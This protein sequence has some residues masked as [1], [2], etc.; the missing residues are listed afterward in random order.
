MKISAVDLFCGAGGLTHGFLLEK[1]PV[2]AGVDIDPTCQFPYE[3]NNH[4]KFINADIANISSSEIDAFYPPDTDIK[5]L[6]GCAPCQPFSAHRYKEQNKQDDPRW[7]LL[8]SFARIAKDIRPNLITMENVPNLEHHEIYNYFVE[9]LQES[10]YHVTC[11]KV[12]CPQYG[13]PQTRRRLVMFGSLYGEVKL[14]NPLPSEKYPTVRQAIAHLEPIVAGGASACDAVHRASNLTDINLRRIKASKPGGTWRDW[15]DDLMLECHKRP[16]GRG[17]LHV[18]GRME[19]DKPAPTITTQCNRLG[20]GRFG[21]PSQDRAI[22]LREA[23]L[24]QTFPENY[25]FI[26]DDRMVSVNNIARLIGNA[27]PVNLGRAIARGLLAH[28]K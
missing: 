20:D 24:L 25:K 14:P 21:H 16:S 3:T 6:A 26:S 7:G 5:I 13:V 11:Y 8:R 9:Q 18:Y 17:Y 4:A 28:I 10:G 12:Y 22:S 2:H 15:S 27:V 23:A 19:W 1:I